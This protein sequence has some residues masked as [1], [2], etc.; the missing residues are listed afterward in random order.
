[1]IVQLQSSAVLPALACFVIGEGE[2]FSADIG[3]GESAGT[4]VDDGVGVST[5]SDEDGDVG[6]GEGAIENDVGGVGAGAVSDVGGGED[7]LKDGSFFAILKYLFITIRL[8]RCGSSACIN[9]HR[10]GPA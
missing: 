3:V 1:M 6:I 10:P 7:G 5:G 2:G 8:V 9:F 4:D